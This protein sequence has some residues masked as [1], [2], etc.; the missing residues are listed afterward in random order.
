MAE[1]NMM[2]K[3]ILL[4]PQTQEETSSGILLSKGTQS[5]QCHNICIVSAVGPDC[6]ENLKE[7]VT[8]VLPHKTGKWLEF[9]GYKYIL[10]TEDDILCIV[11]GIEA[12]KPEDVYEINVSRMLPNPIMTVKKSGKNYQLPF[13][14]EQYISKSIPKEELEKA[15]NDVLEKDANISQEHRKNEKED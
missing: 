13:T 10:A 11:E 12:K 4:D 9:E 1:L 14:S 5:M 6:N 2:G 7:G 3:N 8:V 15:V